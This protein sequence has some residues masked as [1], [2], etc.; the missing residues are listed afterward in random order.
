[1]FRRVT[2]SKLAACLV[3]LAL[4]LAYAVTP[5]LAQEATTTPGTETGVTD[6]TAP[7]TDTGT[8]PSS[9]TGTA[10][11]TDTGTAPGT[12]TGT[13]PGTDTGTTPGTDTGT[14]P[15]PTPGPFTVTGVVIAYSIPGVV[16]T[17]PSGGAADEDQEEEVDEEPAPVS[18]DEAQT[19]P[20]TG[21][22]QTAPLADT[23]PTGPYIT[24]TNQSGEFT[25]PVA[26]TVVIEAPKAETGEY[27]INVGDLAQLSG[28]DGVVDHITV[29]P[30]ANPGGRSR[31]AAVPGIVEAVSPTD[32][33]VKACDGFSYSFVITASTPVF[34]GPLTVSTA[35]ILVGD[36]V[37]VKGDGAG[38][39][40]WIRFTGRSAKAVR[41]FY[42][43]AGK[44]QSG[45]GT[46]AAGGRAGL[47]GSRGR[48]RGNG[49]G[50][51]RGFGNGYGRGRGPKG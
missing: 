12:D 39:A 17:L 13:T 37:V 32:I 2:L 31:Y 19:V 1:M 40:K 45:A 41:E 25:Y 51:G 9:D 8:A 36:Q 34:A 29:T 14:E 6:G 48:G 30:A 21:E 15:A 43:G 22:G 28:T 33:V 23:T 24:V 49:Y 50:F 26:E 20:S 18:T 10:P 42:R 16:T 3:T 35:D 44:A 7:S 27:V 38:N 4:V 47:Y 11:T 46:A 5:A